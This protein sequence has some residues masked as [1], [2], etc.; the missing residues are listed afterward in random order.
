MSFFR[1]L[2][3]IVQDFRYAARVLAREPLFTAVI[4][5]TLALGIGANAAMFGVIDR[6]LLRGPEHVRNPERVTRVYI[7]QSNPDL[8]VRTGSGFGYVTYALLRDRA[9]VFENVAAFTARDVTIGRGEAARQ[10]RVGRAT[11]DLFPMLGVQPVLGRFY[12]GSEDRPPAGQNVVVLSY[13]YWVAH[14]QGTRNVLGKPI[15]IGIGA[16]SGNATSSAFTIIG[17]APRGFAGPAMRRIDMWV[18]M[19]AGSQPNDEWATTWSSLWLEVYG[20]LKPGVTPA[21]A[22]TDVTTV[23]RSGYTGRNKDHLKA[24]LSVAPLRYN[25]EKKETL[26]ITVTR[27][28]VGVSIIVLLVACANVANLLLARATR[29]RREVAVRLALGISRA[30]LVRLLI[31]ESV[32]LASVG[33]IIA[34]AIANWGGQFIRVLL[35]PDVE[36]TTSPL[37]GRVLL[38][39]A[40]ATIAT[41]LF[42]GLF[43]A[44]QAARHDLSSALKAGVR[45]GGVVNSPLRAFLT[46]AQAALSVLLLVGSG[47][48]V[49]SF[50][51]VQHLPLGIEPRRVFS[52]SITGVPAP[53]GIAPRTFAERMARQD[54]IYF[55]VAE[56]LKRVNGIESV[57]LSVGTPFA[58][59]FGIDLKV[60]GW[61]S[62]PQLPGGGPYIS[63]V[64]TDYFKTVG[65]RVL[66]GRGFT[67]AD[68]AGAE[69]VA[70]VNLFMARTLWP[71]E[72]AIGKCLE[73]NGSP[74]CTR[75]VG[76]VENARRF[77]IKE[78]PAM[79]YYIPKGMEKGIGGIALLVRPTLESS[80]RMPEIIR[81]AVLS[82]N[83][84]VGY[85]DVKTMQ[86][87]ID[88]Q[89]RPWKLGA[90]MFVIFAVL[91]LIIAGIGL[92]SVIAYGVAQR[93]LE[94]G[95]RA[96]L[97]A[98]A[99]ELVTLVL[100]QALT[101]AIAG[102]V[103]G[104]LLAL[105]GGN[106]LTPLLFDTSPRDPA[107]F[108]AVTVTL[109]AVAVL[110]GLLPAVRA[111]SANPADALR[112]E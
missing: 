47:L 60:Q 106:S 65:T 15:D 99:G 83:P 31:T 66:R 61:D 58:S 32:L 69:P 17:V 74:E 8:G 93:R 23:Y 89:V 24:E 81:K 63:A 112:A 102:L 109:L 85:V 21:Q 79:Q 40:L 36:W 55:D 51:N 73:I 104:I 12:N 108:L 67:E 6:L 3:S 5:L 91:A 28:V 105:F 42:V 11:W 77:A 30:R 27:W 48:F 41:G 95:I 16:A 54:Q 98:R 101:L 37:S 25:R 59:A 29:R 53:Q 52:V 97:G 64:T 10:V 35:L 33:G 82:I 20:R 45:E 90:T 7:T 56:Q 100:R 78:E 14:F 80:E 92:Y 43:P 68:R 70:L 50:W 107:I 4:V 44:V 94:F 34:L 72:E 2:D 87:R 26:E 96:A 39:S 76:V 62:I 9:R 18:P 19:S 84:N 110:A 46:V 86:E 71:N 103:I 111:R 22:A 88:P 49:R 13:D 57:A 38:I 1:L 75:I